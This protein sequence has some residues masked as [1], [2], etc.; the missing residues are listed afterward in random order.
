MKTTSKQPS[1]IRVAVIGYGGSFNM[2]RAHLTEMKKAGMTPTAVAEIDPARLDAAAKDFPGIETYSSV[3]AM[4]KQS[5]ADLITIITPHNSHAKLA[6]QCLRAGR[7]VVVE[8]PM[9]I[10]TAECDA[11]I[12]AARANKVMLSTYHNRHWDGWIM[13]AVER[14]RAGVIGELYRVEAH[15]GRWGKPGDWWRSSKSISGGILYDWGVHLLEYSLQLIDSEIVEVTGFAKTGVWANATRW[16]ADTNEDEGDVIVRFRNGVWLRLT[17][18]QLDSNPKRGQLEITGTKGTYLIDFPNYEIITHA[19]PETVITR[20]KSRES[21]GWRFYQNVADHLTKG[22]RLII[23]PE[24]ARR[25][26]H[27]LDLANRSARLGRA[28]R[29]KYG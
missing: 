19:G 7:H 3:A 16:K 29:A 4:L 27:I 12:A 24:W 17:I 9:A 28:L 1:D 13:E 22:D 23:S 26:I 11:M 5:A 21:E 18:S 14:I 25:P 10:T 20:G 2:G 15:M 6:L 8:K